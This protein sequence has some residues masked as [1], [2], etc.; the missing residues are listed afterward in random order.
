MATEHILVPRQKYEQ[1]TMAANSNNVLRDQDT[2]KEEQEESHE[3]VDNRDNKHIESDDDNSSDDYP[4]PADS[5]DSGAS[6][7]NITEEGDKSKLKTV[8][9]KK[10]KIKDRDSSTNVHKKRTRDDIIPR[11]PGIMKK[12]IDIGLGKKHSN[13]SK[14]K[15]K[16][17]NNN[18]KRWIKW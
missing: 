11:P 6:E 3:N 1:L 2:P 9:K 7:L 5:D 13:I 10:K 18:I 15:Y 14:A 16:K 17:N 4:S 12:D 8:D